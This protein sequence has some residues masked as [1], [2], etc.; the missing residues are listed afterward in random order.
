[1][2]PSLGLITRTSVRY[3]QHTYAMQ[4]SN[5]DSTEETDENLGAQKRSQTLHQP[6]KF[7]TNS[8]TTFFFRYL[9]H[10]QN[11]NPQKIV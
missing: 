9:E 1:V 8:P 4:V 11:E 3:Q 10:E 2:T 5:A 7:A 6:W